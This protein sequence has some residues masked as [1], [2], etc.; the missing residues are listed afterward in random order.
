MGTTMADNNDPSYW[1]NIWIG[2]G[3]VLAGLGASF[4]LK[5]HVAPRTRTPTG[6]A[7]R[8]DIRKLQDDLRD[9]K[10][11]IERMRELHVL[12]AEKIGILE[13]D[14]KIVTA[15]IFRKLGDISI[16]LTEVMTTM[17]MIMRE[18]RE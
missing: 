5:K 9:I 4:K 11:D 14:Q 18:S 13:G 16:G 6:D 12:Q 15:E 1:A 17:K 3:G 8:A 10:K 2:L 7:V